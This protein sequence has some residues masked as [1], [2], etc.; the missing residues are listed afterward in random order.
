M[1]AGDVRGDCKSGHVYVPRQ[2]KTDYLGHQ[3]VV[4]VGPKAWATLATWHA[5]AAAIG[6]D[7]PN[8]YGPASGVTLL[9]D[10]AVGYVALLGPGPGTPGVPTL[11][12]PRAPR[13]GTS[14]SAV[15]GASGRRGRR[16]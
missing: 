2:H 14:S 13:P 12:T 6:P 10:E 11:A 1:R 4:A 9:V 8:L 7:A 3:R 16:P 5:A 15:G